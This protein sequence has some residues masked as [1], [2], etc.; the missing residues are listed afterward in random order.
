M[1]IHSSVVLKLKHCKLQTKRCFYHWTLSKTTQYS[2][3]QQYTSFLIKFPCF[4]LEPFSVYKLNIYFLAN[5]YFCALSAFH[6][7]SFSFCLSFFPPPLILSLLYFLSRLC[8]FP[9][10]L[11]TCFP[12]CSVISCYFHFCEKNLACTLFKV[13]II[14]ANF[15]SFFLLREKL[16]KKFFIC[17]H[18]IIKQITWVYGSSSSRKIFIFSF[19]LLL[20]LNKSTHIHT[21][22]LHTCF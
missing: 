1:Y 6:S 15:T 4:P 13:N 16:K 8:I 7:S 3:S 21:H 19:Y 22:D 12:S 20:S 5:Y 11:S 18:N 17:I 2:V 9:P 14:R 10:C